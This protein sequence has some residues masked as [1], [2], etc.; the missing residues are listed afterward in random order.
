[1]NF[2]KIPKVE[3]PLKSLLT[4]KLWNTITAIAEGKKEMDSILKNHFPG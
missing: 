2:P 1:K 4:P 3:Q